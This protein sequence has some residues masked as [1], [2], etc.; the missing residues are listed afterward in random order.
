M[1]I[2]ASNSH[3]ELSFKC[4]QQKYLMQKEKYGYSSFINMPKMLRGIFNENKLVI[5]QG[6]K[7]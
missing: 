3:N 1:N 5:I 4:E 2:V 7:I 6:N